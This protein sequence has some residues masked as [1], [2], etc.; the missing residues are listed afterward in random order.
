M[1]EGHQVETMTDEA[2]RQLLTPTL[3][4]KAEPVFA[5]MA[6]RPRCAWWSC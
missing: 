5:R 2:L 6:P 1:I 4:D 3:P